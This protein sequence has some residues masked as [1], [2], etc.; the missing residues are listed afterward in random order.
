MRNIGVIMT[1][2][3]LDAFQAF[4]LLAITA[5]SAGGTAVIG[6]VP[7]AGTAAAGAA[8]LIGAGGAAGI[9]AVISATL[10]SGF[11]ALLF[12]NGLMSLQDFIS[13][14]K[15]P[16]MLGKF[17][18][19]INALPLYTALAV[20]CILEQR[21]K[22]RGEQA[23]ER[24][25]GIRASAQDEES[26]EEAPLQEQ[27]QQGASVPQATN[28]NRAASRARVPITDIRPRAGTLPRAANDTLSSTAYGAAA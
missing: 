19:F 17:V 2:L 12:F 5:I 26:A 23:S 20:R 18:P 28:D 25:A 24:T 6:L 15:T 13:L 3:T 16:F 27:P 9:D 8:D 14:R 22:E 21:A 10:G 11:I 1:A 7:V 4:L